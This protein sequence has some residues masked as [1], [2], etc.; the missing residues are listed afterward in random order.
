MT[1]SDRIYI[2]VGA[3]E[4][5]ENGEHNVIDITKAG[6]FALFCV[7]Q[8]ARPVDGEIAQAVVQLDCAVCTSK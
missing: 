5:L 4:Q 7:V 8:T 3:L 2:R 6:G 1:G